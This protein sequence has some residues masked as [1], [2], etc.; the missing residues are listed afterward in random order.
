MV[1]H[2]AFGAEGAWLK[3]Q[4]HAHS[5]NSDGELPA[6]AVAR[7][8]AHHG[9]DVLT[10]SDHWTMTKIDGPP[11]L[12]LVP[13]AEL[14]VDPVGGPMCPEFLAI[15][16]DDVPEEPNGDRANWYPYENSVIK[17][18]ATFDDG[19]AYVEEFGGAS[20]LCHPSWSGLPQATVFAA[21]A[22]HGI[23]VWNASAHREND[24]GDSA[25]LWDLALDAGLSFAPFATDDSHYPAFDVNDAWTMVRAADRTRE[26]VVAALRAGH[27]YASNGPA[28]HDIARDGDA[29][30]VRCSPAQDVWLHGAW[31]EG[32]GASAGPRGRLEDAAVL[33]RDDRGLIVRV[34]FAPGENEWPDRRDRRWWRVVVADERGRRAW[35]NVV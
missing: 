25:V 16:I 2:G 23:E 34:R 10:I 12:L 22:M 5:L 6:E 29:V 35:S 30:E 31:E 17:T 1:E 26:A 3:A 27:V 4:F 18:F 32:V 33:E 19:A 9:F 7:Q 8:Y 24:R 28:I 20:V 14:M 21:R 15:G 11:G 13:G